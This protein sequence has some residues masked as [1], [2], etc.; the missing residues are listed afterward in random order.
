MA[1]VGLLQS[2][3][4]GL[5]GREHDRAQDRQAAACPATSRALRDQGLLLARTRHVEASVASIFNIPH[6]ALRASTRGKADVARARQVAMYLCHTTLA[7]SLTTVGRLFDRDRTTV[8]HAC[9]LV[10]DLRDNP[11]FDAMLVLLER[12]ILAACLPAHSSSRALEKAHA[13]A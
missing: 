13:Y 9:R 11:D 2:A 10:E 1:G 7:L 12:T 6:E 5:N 3:Q 4:C 8:G